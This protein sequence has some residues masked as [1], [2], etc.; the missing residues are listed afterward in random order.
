MMRQCPPANQ[1]DAMPDTT[2]GG[3]LE[4]VASVI[5]VKT[6][7]SWHGVRDEGPQPRPK[8]APRA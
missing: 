6:E 8:L 5:Q 2:M 7:L 1:P 4:G 3:P